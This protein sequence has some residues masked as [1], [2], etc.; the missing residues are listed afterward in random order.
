MEKLSEMIENI[1]QLSADARFE[2]N[3]ENYDALKTK[4][5]SIILWSEQVLK[6]LEKKS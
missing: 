4:L 2:N 6:T 3:R 5:E 1:E